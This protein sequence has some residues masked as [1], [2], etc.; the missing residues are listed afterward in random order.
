MSIKM[1]NVINKFLLAVDNFIP[2][3]NLRL[4][5]FT[6]SAWGLFKTKSKTKT[7][8]FKEKEDSRYI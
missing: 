7:Q 5:L 8:K 3:I 4:P 2:E 6:Y 1:N